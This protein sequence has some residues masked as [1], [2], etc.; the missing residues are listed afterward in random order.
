MQIQGSDTKQKPEYIQG[1]SLVKLINVLLNYD[2]IR[3]LIFV[4]L[5]L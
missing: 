1:L 5:S 4:I 3:D 2:Y